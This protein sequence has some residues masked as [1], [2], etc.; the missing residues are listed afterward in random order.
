MAVWAASA[1]LPLFA[2]QGMLPEDLGVRA[3]LGLDRGDTWTV[4][5]VLSLSLNALLFG[6][7]SIATTQA[8]DEADAARICARQALATAPV[9]AAPL[10]S[11]ADL[12]RALSR[13][14]G[15]STASAE[16]A[17]AAHELSLSPDEAHPAELR[18]LRDRVEQN[19]SGLFGPVLARLVVDPE[20]RRHEGDTALADQLRFLDQRLR[21]PA[22]ELTGI[23]SELDLLRRYL[24]SV[25]E[26]LPSGV[27]A[28]D[29]DG[30]V[31]LWNRDLARVTGLPPES[32]VGLPIERLPLP[33]G[34]ALAAFA[35]EEGASET[36][37]DLPLGARRI[38]LH[39]HKASLDRAAL[40]E[41]ETDGQAPFGLVL[42]VEDRTER[43]ALEAQLVHK[44]RLASVGRLAAGVAHEIGN[45]VTGIA[46]LAQNMLAEG[47]PEES[48]ARAEL[49]LDQTARIDGIV[50][51]L[52]G[53]SREGEG[54]LG[55]A[56][57]RV[58]RTRLVS[59]VD[60][61]IALVRLDRRGKQ[62]RME[63]LLADDLFVL[64]D[65]QRL[66]QVVVNLLTNACDASSP[67]DEVL[68]DAEPAGESVMLRV[69]DHGAGM[70][71]EQQQRAFEPF[72][73]TK[74]PA[75][76]TGLGLSLVY[77]IVHEHGGE[78]SIESEPGAGTTVRVRLPIASHPGEDS[79]SSPGASA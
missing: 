13:V 8:D 51:S 49:I 65:R 28:L 79:V 10:R 12:E 1:L 76:G 56:R 70:S 32:T 71:K 5:T 66:T 44:D 11:S 40:G 77:S 30:A 35:R 7:V 47:L 38:S 53:Y 22:P 15:A 6:A 43:A 63:N 45:P 14:L 9:L 54:L 52:L 29:P 60:E 36:D 31:I 46:C 62:I 2:S 69:I 50:R 24:R 58:E 4:P 39:L 59:V 16:I 74:P 64:G 67:G 61:A 17:R 68:V 27:C 34:P 23:A 41:G 57:P 3:A 37:L 78:V 75:E 55:P 72:F 19:L 48:R 21:G 33:W 42:L 25:L 20:R 18:R 26:E 73:T